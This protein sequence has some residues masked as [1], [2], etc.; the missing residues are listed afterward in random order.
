ME[1]K[2]KPINE[3]TWCQCERFSCEQTISRMGDGTLVN[4][5]DIRFRCVK[6]EKGAI[7]DRTTIDG[8][9]YEGG[10]TNNS[11]PGCEIRPRVFWYRDSLGRH[12]NKVEKEK[13][14]QKKKEK[15]KKPKKKKGKWKNL[16]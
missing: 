10:H 8:V 13:E 3:V 4:R 14:G 9:E 2:Q 12:E 15:K 1:I 7:T 6:N 5:Q 11:I 16:V